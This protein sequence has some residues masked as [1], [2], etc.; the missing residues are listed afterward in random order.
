MGNNGQ[1]VSHR[2]Q[3]H[4]KPLLDLV[5]SITY[6]PE[7]LSFEPDVVTGWDMGKR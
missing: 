1:S 4:E 2:K 6:H 3:D 7:I 5:E